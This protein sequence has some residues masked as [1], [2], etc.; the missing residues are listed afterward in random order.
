MKGDE[1]HGMVYVYE[2]YIHD[3]KETVLRLDLKQPLI[4]FFLFEGTEK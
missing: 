1:N 3:L 2:S 4:F